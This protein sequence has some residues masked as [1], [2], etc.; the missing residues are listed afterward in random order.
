VYQVECLVIL[1]GLVPIWWL[2]ADGASFRAIGATNF[3][4]V[5]QNLRVRSIGSNHTDKSTLGCV[6]VGG[7]KGKAPCTVR[8]PSFNFVK[9]GSLG[10]IGTLKRFGLRRADGKTTNVSAVRQNSEVVAPICDNGHIRRNAGRHGHSS[11]H[12]VAPKRVDGFPAVAPYC[13]RLRLGLEQVPS[14]RRIQRACTV[15]LR[16]VTLPEI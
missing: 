3:V 4:S 1:A 6:G 8:K 9:P 7:S 14:G 12:V 13:R 10:K 16:Q 11:H 15:N 2:A 5:H